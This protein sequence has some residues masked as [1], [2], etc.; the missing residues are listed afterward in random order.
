MGCI[1]CKR[2]VPRAFC[3]SCRSTILKYKEHHEL[4]QPVQYAE[5]EVID[6]YMRSLYDNRVLFGPLETLESDITW[7][8]EDQNQVIYEHR[9]RRI[10]VNWKKA[11]L[12]FEQ[13][14]GD[15]EIVYQSQHEDR[16]NNMKVIAERHNLLKVNEFLYL[17][18]ALALRFF[19]ENSNVHIDTSNTELDFNLLK[20]LTDN[21]FKIWRITK[22]LIKKEIKS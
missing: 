16:L 9:A 5:F 11:K 19:P 12:Y 6:D 3:I 13:V 20:D 8:A 17:K 18:E 22:S 10:I 2:P 21:N 14:L 15:Y 1:I 7:T 4:Q